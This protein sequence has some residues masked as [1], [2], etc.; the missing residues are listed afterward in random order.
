MSDFGAG[1]VPPILY[2]TTSIDSVC[3]PEIM[4]SAGGISSSLIIV[5]TAGL[6]PPAVRSL[7]SVAKTDGGRF[8]ISFAPIIAPLLVRNVWA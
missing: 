8:G 5:W 1:R 3:W 6:M 7:L 2:L 4:N